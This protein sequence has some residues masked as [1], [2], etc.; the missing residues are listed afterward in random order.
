MAGGPASSAARERGP[1]GSRSP[2]RGPR[3]WWRGLARRTRVTLLASSAFVVLSVGALLARYLSAENAERDADL[4]LVRAEARGDVG[5]MLDRLSGC[6]A[7]AKCV[8]QVRAL[9]RDARVR[10]SGEVKLLQVESKTAGSLFGATGKTRLA[11]TVLG[12]KPVVQCLLI[13]RSGNPL[14]GIDVELLSIGAPIAGEAKC[15]PPSEIERFEEEA[16]EAELEEH[17]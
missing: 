15:S 9:A 6:R 3:V 13:R 16:T 12:G 7:D 10:A 1:R 14:T 4:A 5:A 8:A 17:K 2:E 11:W